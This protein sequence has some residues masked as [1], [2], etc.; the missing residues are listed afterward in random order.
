MIFHDYIKMTE[1]FVTNNSPAILT[2]IGVV[3]VVSTAYLTGKATFKAAEILAEEERVAALVAKSSEKTL[4]EKTKLVWTLY[5]PAVATGTTTCAAIIGA[6]YISNRRAA[7]MAAAFTLS[8][9][10]YSEYRDKVTEHLGKNKEQ[11]VRDDI[12]QDR[13]T[14]NP[15]T[16]VVT[17]DGNVMCYD[18]YSGRY[19]ESKMEDLKWA[20]NNLNHKI[21]N[22]YYASL[23]DFYNLIG[24]P[25]TEY[26]EEVGWNSDELLELQFS[27]VM[28]DDQ[29]PC[30]AIN[31]RCS[32]IRN[33]HRIH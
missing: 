5:I 9:K 8:E 21:I 18:A 30:I 4:K 7:A 6:N 16:L 29:K 23:G 27:T 25:S 28:S 17:G 24:L 26:S 12:Q 1:R 33:Y 13:V 11:R 22:D 32:P 2:G 3:G 31:F 10:A 20:Q 14:N 15:S 19:F